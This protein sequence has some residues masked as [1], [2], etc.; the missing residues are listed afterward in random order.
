MTNVA[1][2]VLY[3]GVTGNLINRVYQH[4]EKLVEGF[5]NKYNIIKLVYYET[6]ESIESAILREKVIKGWL[7]KKKIDLIDSMNPEW[8]DLYLDLC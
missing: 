2:K 1:N 8:R 5:T 4:K 7:R 6:C 3:I